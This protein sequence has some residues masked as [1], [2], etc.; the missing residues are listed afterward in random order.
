M[1]R[2]LQVTRA[3]YAVTFARWLHWSALEETSGGGDAADQSD[4]DHRQL[5]S[6][7][8]GAVAQVLV[9]AA[10]RVAAETR[11]SAAALRARRHAGASRC[12]HAAHARHW[13]LHT[14]IGVASRRG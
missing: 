12:L 14:H 11:H 3:L 6:G 4:G 1:L 7:L 9:L 10:V 13:F 2:K 8:H 5:A